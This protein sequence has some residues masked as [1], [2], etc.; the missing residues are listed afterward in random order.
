[1]ICPS[2]GFKTENDSGCCP[3]C[4]CS[5]EPERRRVRIRLRLSPEEARIGARRSVRLPGREEPLRMKLPPELRDGDVLEQR[6]IRLEPPGKAPVIVTLLMTVEIIAPPQPRP[7]IKDKPAEIKKPQKP[8][9]RGCLAYIAMIFLALLLCGAIVCAFLLGS[10]RLSLEDMKK[11]RPP[12]IKSSTATAEV[13]AQAETEL[14]RFERRGYIKQLDDRLLADVLAIYR[15]AMSFEPTATLPNALTEHELISICN[16]MA[17]DCTE[18]LQ[19]DLFSKRW[20]REPDGSIRTLYMSYVMDKPE[21]ETARAECRSMAERLA[22]ETEGMDDASRE[23]YVYN[24]LTASCSYTRDS[25]HAFSPYGAFVLGGA[26]CD[27]LSKAMKWALDEMGIDCFCVSGAYLGRDDG[28]TWCTVQLDGTWYDVDVTD[29]VNASGAW[30]PSFRGAVNV[31]ADWVRSRFELDPGLELVTVPAGEDMSRSAHVLDG[32]FIYSGQDTASR[33]FELLDANCPY[34]GAV[35]IQL[36]DAAAFEYLKEN[37]D[38]LLTDW[39]AQRFWETWSYQSWYS[40]AYRTM[41]IQTA[42]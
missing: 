16:L 38:R 32:S 13:R 29:D 40:D 35:C 4:G 27:G 10:G 1:M 31:S 24:Y 11:I 28:H 42:Q 23:L 33:L 3:H 17:L 26:K 12:T 19:T 30:Q 2:C 34:G 41:L 7:E 18:L 9:K 21:Y 6:G 37:L 5:L 20:E 36:E 15:A 8:K 25:E 39:F 22:A 14:W